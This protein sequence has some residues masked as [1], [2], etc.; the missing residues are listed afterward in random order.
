MNSIKMVD[1][2]IEFL[3]QCSGTQDIQLVQIL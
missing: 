2:K 1:E 3:P